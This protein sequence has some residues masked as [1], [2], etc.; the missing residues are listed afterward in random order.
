MQKSVFVDCCFF[1]C[2]HG[3][4]EEPFNPQETIREKTRLVRIYLQEWILFYQDNFE[5][6]AGINVLVSVIFKI[7][8]ECNL[9]NES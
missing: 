8:R 2:F 6:F 3:F 4:D 5:Y 7:S 1:S 9:T